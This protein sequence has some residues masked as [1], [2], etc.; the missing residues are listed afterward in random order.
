MTRQYR[1]GDVLL[2]A[3]EK[4][5]SSAFSVAHRGNRAVIAEGEL[6]GHAHA[7]TAKGMRFLGRGGSR[8]SFLVLRYGGAALMH[9]EHAPIPLPE[10]RYEIRRQRQYDPQMPRRV[11]D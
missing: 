1:Q 7:V 10:G 2:C 3:I 5:P 4:V 8:Q 11:R 9:E 6:S